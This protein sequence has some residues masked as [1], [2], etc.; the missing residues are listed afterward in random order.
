MFVIGVILDDL[1]FVFVFLEDREFITLWNRMV[2]PELLSPKMNIF[3][4]FFLFT[5]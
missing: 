1:D 4:I 3:L 5:N 2:L